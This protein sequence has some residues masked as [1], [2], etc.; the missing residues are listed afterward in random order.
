MQFYLLSLKENI[1]GIIGPKLYLLSFYSA[2]A[3]V[4]LLDRSWWKFY[5]NKDSI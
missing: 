3:H 4:D 2:P 1:S 5:P